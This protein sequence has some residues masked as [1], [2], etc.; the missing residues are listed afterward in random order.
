MEE[1]VLDGL[2]DA[3][4]GEITYVIPRTAILDMTLGN[5]V[6]YDTRVTAEKM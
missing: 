6:Y 2:G 1:T 4:V 5:A 3:S